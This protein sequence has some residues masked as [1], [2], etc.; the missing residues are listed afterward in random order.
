MTFCPLIL[1]IMLS[2]SDLPSFL[3]KEYPVSCL[4]R[5]VGI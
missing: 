4:L 5:K 1:S 3:T 2:N